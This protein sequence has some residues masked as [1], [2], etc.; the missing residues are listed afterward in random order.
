MCTEATNSQSARAH[1][2]L[3]APPDRP[4]RTAYVPSRR[5]PRRPGERRE[6]LAVSLSPALAA[7]AAE[8]ELDLGCATELCL[9][10]ALVIAD[11]AVLAGP[12]LYDERLLAAAAH[13]TVSRPLPA[14]KARYLQMLVAARDRDAVVVDTVDAIE[15]ADGADETVVDIPLRLFPRVATV[16]D[17]TTSVGAAHLA[18]ALTLEIG[19][20]SEGR[21]MSEWA[22][23]AVLRFSL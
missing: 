14:A 11:L 20:V 10:R 3:L 17:E 1:L 5:L 8:R 6:P 15:D 12:E 9:E 2:H 22:A 13:A 21:T 18:E 19:A 23:L 16:V 7:A 4:L